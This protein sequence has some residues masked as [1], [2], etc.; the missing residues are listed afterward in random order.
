MNNHHNNHYHNHNNA[1]K[2]PYYIH[3]PNLFQYL[4]CVHFCLSGSHR[5]ISS[6][7]SLV[8]FCGY[9]AHWAQVSWDELTFEFDEVHLRLRA[10]AFCMYVCAEVTQDIASL[11]WKAWFPL[12]GHL[13]KRDRFIWPYKTLQPVCMCMNNVL[14]E[15][16][17]GN[18]ICASKGKR[19]PHG[20][21]M[22]QWMNE[23]LDGWKASGSYWYES[24]GQDK[25]CRVREAGW[26]CSWVK[27]FPAL[28]IYDMWTQGWTYPWAKGWYHRTW[29][30]VSSISPR[31]EVDFFL[32]FTQSLWANENHTRAICLRCT[33]G[34]SFETLHFRQNV[35]YLNAEQNVLWLWTNERQSARKGHSN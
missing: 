34:L 25:T 29:D 4:N 14:T 30:I 21:S 11:L 5:I 13:K 26:V 12:S 27:S 32:T 15:G 16:A 10:C 2:W 23:W 28:S 19:N 6:L 3:F 8:P 18:L 9:I 33:F 1:F 24:S 22:G 20:W 35:S 17:E 7:P 31:Q